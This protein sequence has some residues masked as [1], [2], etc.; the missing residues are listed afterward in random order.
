[1]YSDSYLQVYILTKPLLMFPKFL[2]N[3]INVNNHK[4]KWHKL[5]INLLVQLT[6]SINSTLILFA[7]K[8][9]LK[10][11]LQLLYNL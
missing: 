8:I 10:N 1:M 9:R 3:D 5:I 6:V 11:C 4:K 7:I 2:F